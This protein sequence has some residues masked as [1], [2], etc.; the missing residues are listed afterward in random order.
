MALSGAVSGILAAE[1]SR[2]K[3]LKLGLEQDKLQQERNQFDFDRQQ[4]RQKVLGGIADDALAPLKDFWAKALAGRGKVDSK[5]LSLF[6]KAIGTAKDAFSASGRDPRIVDALRDGILSSVTTGIKPRIDAGSPAGKSVADRELFVDQF[7]AKSPQVKAFDDSNKKTAGP[8][9][10]DVSSI[11]GQFLRESRDFVSVR[12]A[13]GKITA[14]SQDPSAAGDLALIFNFM[15][16]LDPGSVVREGEFATAQNSTGVPDRVRNFY[17]RLLTGER[18]GLGQRQDFVSQSEKI[19]ESVIKSQELLERTFGGI[20]ERSGMKS[21]NVI[22]DLI[23][24]FRAKKD[25]TAKGKKERKKF[26]AQ[27]NPI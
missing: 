4:A 16:L 11:R 6:H 24:G 13:F 12:D 19:F 17:N 5:T 22:V 27:G 15:K 1:E 8:K 21:S 18:L 9:L 2:N 23:G 26:D 25:N 20:A 10:S 14:A 7:G 3:K